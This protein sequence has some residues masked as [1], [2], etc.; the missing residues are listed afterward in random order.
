MQ[1]SDPAVYLWGGEPLLRGD[2]TIGE[3]TSAGWG[4]EAGRC[5]ALAYVRGELA[6]QPLKAYAAMADVWGQSVAVVIDDLG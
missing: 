6:A 3:I 2:Q 1:C 5:V 4:W